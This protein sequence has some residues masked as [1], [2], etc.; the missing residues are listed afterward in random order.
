MPTSPRTLGGA[1]SRYPGRPAGPAC[2][3]SGL[4]GTPGTDLLTASVL[5]AAAK[6][7]WHEVDLTKFQ[8]RTPEAGFYI[9]MEWLYT[10]D[11]FGCEHLV[12]IQATKE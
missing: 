8:L 1:A 6:K 2:P 9:A 5:A 3:G 12:T 11:R 7:G 4:G 10:A